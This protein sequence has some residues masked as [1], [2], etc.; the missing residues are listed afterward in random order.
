MSGV[1]LDGRPIPA[2]EPY[3]HLV[4]VVGLHPP[5]ATIFLTLRSVRACMDLDPLSV[6]LGFG[7]EGKIAETSEDFAE[8]SGDRAE[9]RRE[10][11]TYSTFSYHRCFSR[12]D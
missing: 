11:Y 10:R 3:P 4:A 12:C 9:H 6:K 2:E 7:C 8:G 1:R 5:T